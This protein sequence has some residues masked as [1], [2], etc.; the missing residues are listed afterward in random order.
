MKQ[1]AY[2]NARTADLLPE[3]EAELAQMAEEVP[4]MPADFHDKW[5]KAV[6]EDAEKNQAQPAEKK[7]GKVVAI[8]RGPWSRLIS[9]AAVFVFLIGGTVLYRAGKKTIEPMMQTQAA[10]SAP[11]ETAAPAETRVPEI[12]VDAEESFGTAYEASG[13]M[14]STAGEEADSFDAYA[15]G[16]VLEEAA[17]Y[18]E[19]EEAE[20]TEAAEAAGAAER[21]AA[22]A[23]SVNAD[24]AGGEV[25]A[26]PTA[27]PTEA[28]TPEVT[29]KPTPVPA[30]QPKDA[31]GFLQQ[32]G[33]FMADMAAFLFSV[34][35]WLAAA[36]VIVAA[37][38]VVRRRK[39]RS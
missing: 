17:E 12:E 1:E 2:E 16:A 10:D 4:P 19:A 15:G 9:V 25:T 5:M 38:L 3:L 31:P 36:A 30:E 33:G 23:A 6:R 34:W 21:P 14:V 35:P 11:V 37:W 29:E 32:A 39:T 22:K 26:E 13:A 7:T 8:T 20:A 28:P 27:A 24:R 18:E